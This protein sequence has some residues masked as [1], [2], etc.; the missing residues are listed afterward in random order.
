M[1]ET[2]FLPELS[3]KDLRQIQKDF[4]Q[5]LEILEK[6]H[7]DYQSLSPEAKESFLASLHY[8]FYLTK[9]LAKKKFTPKKYRYWEK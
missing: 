1:L 4:D 7:A 2:E 8:T 3:A 5:E 6:E 9:R